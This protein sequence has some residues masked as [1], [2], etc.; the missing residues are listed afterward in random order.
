M[1]QLSYYGAPPESVPHRA[2][3]IIW[4]VVL[5]VAGAFLTC[6]GV[7]GVGFLVVANVANRG[8]SASPDAALQA[9]AS[10]L[11]A[12][13][14][15][16]AF[17]WLGI[18]C[19]QGKRW[20]RP[21][22]IVGCV[23]TILFAVLSIGPTIYRFVNVLNVH[24]VWKTATTAPATT[25]PMPSVST[26]P[27]W[28]GTVGA[29]IGVGGMLGMMIVLPAFM[30]NFFRQQTVRLSLEM[31]DPRPRWTDRVPIPVLGW[32]VG[33]VVLG[34]GQLFGSL[35]SVFPLFNT[36]LTGP[37]AAVG[38]LLLGSL[39]IV[40]GWLSYRRSTIGWL[41]A[42]TALVFLGSSTGAFALLGDSDDYQKRLLAGLS[43]GTQ[44][45]DRVSTEGLNPS[46]VSALVT[47]VAVGY[48]VWVRPRIPPL[49]ELHEVGG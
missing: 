29:V 30:L 14:M 5:I 48:G 8:N 23:I 4:G 49:T 36:L 41:I 12:V 31:T 21:L 20:V 28:A 10:L 18:G 32:F 22:V 19:C 25:A 38:M 34:F 44:R 45:A 42:M 2:G 46:L 39:L 9:A 16:V 43:F 26:P 3:L 7:F 11:P 24:P 35:R 27:A 1:S 17:I 37:V 6:G 33:C 40:G 47:W 15:Y 13:A